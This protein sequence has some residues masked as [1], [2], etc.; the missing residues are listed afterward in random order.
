MADA[1][2]HDERLSPPFPT[3]VDG[4]TPTWLTGVLGRSST[5]GGGPDRHVVEIGTEPVGVG[6]GLLGTLHRVTLTW[7]DGRGPSSIVVKGPASGERSHEIAALFDLYATEVGFYRD[8]AAATG[9]AVPCHHAESAPRAQ[10]FVLVLADRSDDATFD[11]I[12][13]CPPNRASAVVTALAD[14]HARHWDGD[15]LATAGWLRRLDHRDLVDAFQAALHATWPAVRARFPDDV[16]P[17]LALGDRLE[18]MVPVV[19]AALARG[20]VTLAHG[21]ARLDNMFFAADGGVTLCD[22]QLTGASR[23][24]RDLAY[25]LTQSLTSADRAACEQPLIDVY[26]ARLAARGVTGYGAAEAWEDYRAATVLGL[27][28]AVVAG[29]GLDQATPYSVALTRTM[30][31]RAATAVVDHDAASLG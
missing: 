27:V 28:Y 20:P 5:T 13:G 11:Q 10:A 31:R 7:S 30:M 9:V 26:L 18:T 21:D 1:T 2:E 25:F 16:A 4:L 3:T 22:W 6:V 23:G 8:L 24:V 14:L 29:G 19:L 15:G 12:T 17:I